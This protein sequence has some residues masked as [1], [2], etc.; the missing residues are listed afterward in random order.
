MAG[1]KKPAIPQRLKKWRSEG[2]VVELLGMGHSSEGLSPSA[3]C[4][5]T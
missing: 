4:L 2:T 3:K 5:L 1:D